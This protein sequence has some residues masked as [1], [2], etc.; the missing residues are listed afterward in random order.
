MWPPESDPLAV[1]I[2][3]E[4][5]PAAVERESTRLVRETWGVLPESDL[6]VP[7]LRFPKVGLEA[8]S[9]LVGFSKL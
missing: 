1:V 8:E 7:E 3:P 5:W 6:L 4:L 9:T 2:S